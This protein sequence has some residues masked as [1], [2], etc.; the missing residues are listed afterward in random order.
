MKIKCVQNYENFK[1]LKKEWNELLTKIHNKN[2]FL[3]YE[4]MITWYQYYGR[5][6]KLYILLFY[7][8]DQIVGIMPFY[9]YYNRFLFAKKIVIMELLGSRTSDHLDFILMREYQ[10]EILKEADN[11]LKKV[12]FWDVIKLY[13]F[14]EASYLVKFI[15]NK[16]IF[17]YTALSIVQNTVCPYIKLPESWEDYQNNISLNTRRNFRRYSKRLHKNLKN[18]EIKKCKN[19]EEIRTIFYRLIEMN[20]IRMKKINKI[21]NFTN[22]LFVD[23]HIHIA[24]V[25]LKNDWLNLEYIVMNKN[26]LAIL[27]SFKYKNR[28]FSYGTAFDDKFH[29]SKYSLGTVMLGNSIKN[30]IAN[31]CIEFD[32]M[33]GNEGYK[34]KWTNQ[35]RKNFVIEIYSV[36]LSGQLIRIKSFFNRLTLSLK[37]H[38]LDLSKKI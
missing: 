3:T 5:K 19:K 9:Y 15:N 2:I 27:Y 16:K 31:H 12:N 32:L 34:Y 11:Y 23:F 28:I 20:T 36:S 35:F 7:K 26:I 10:Y 14:D 22:N 8:N 24:E 17:N 18:V 13:D 37:I 25:F 4:W 21:S 29:S 6:S 38:L 33:R 30:A 1:R